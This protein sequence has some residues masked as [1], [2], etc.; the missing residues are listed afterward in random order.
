MTRVHWRSLKCVFAFL[1]LAASPGC[2]FGPEQMGR[3]H[4]SYN[5]ALR[6]TGDDELL[7]NIVRLRYLD[8]VEFLAISSISSQ[9]S[10]TVALGA[11]GGDTAI[12]GR[13]ATGTG[14]VSYSTRPTFTF[15]PQRGEEFSRRLVEPVH[16]DI[17]TDLVGA[18][19]DINLMFRLLVRS[20][21]D[22]INDIGLPDPVFNETAARL[23]ALQAE[24]RL[25]VGY[26]Q[27]TETLSDPIDSSR[28]SGTD[29]VE[30]ARAG[31]RFSQAAEKDTFV[32]TSE[33][34][35]AVLALS[36]EADQTHEIV[37]ALRLAP[38]QP[39]YELHEGTLLGEPREQY[40]YLTLRTRSLMGAIL[41][42]AHGVQVPEEHLE[43][44]L[45]TEHWP[46]GF[47]K[48]LNIDDLFIVHN[49]KKRPQADRAVLY[50]DHWFYIDDADST[51][52]ITFMYL[53]ELFRLGLARETGQETPILTLPIGG[54]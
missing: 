30:A 1:A 54:P 49:S 31:F 35:Q 53:A 37:R 22:R 40:E 6:T 48:E 3:G 18:D 43:L 23:G 4:L 7:L 38:G 19:W 9:L 26:V 36:P 14:E 34:R 46:P 16:L 52:R 28:V 21:N 32:L 44:G 45:T 5:E 10:F 24:A 13:I 50:R 15:I 11:E 2:T 12:F 41:Y 51:T 20:M 33:R 42:L 47:E 29:L 8:T 39:Y 25:T 27:R 17:L